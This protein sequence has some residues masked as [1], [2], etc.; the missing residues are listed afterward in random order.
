MEPA[1]LAA[2]PYPEPG[3]SSPR[4]TIPRLCRSTLIL[5]YHLLLGLPSGFCP[6]DFPAKSLHSPPMSFFLMWSPVLWLVDSK[7]SWRF[8]LCHFL[9]SPVTSLLLGPDIFLYALLSNTFSTYASFSVTDQFSFPYKTTGR[10][11][12]QYI[13]YS[14]LRRPRGCEILD[15]R[16]MMIFTG[17]IMKWD[18]HHWLRIE[19]GWFSHPKKS[20]G[21]IWR[22]MHRASSCNM[23]INQQD[24]QISVIKLYFPLDTLHVSVYISPSSGAT[25]Y[26]SYIAF[27]MFSNIILNVNVQ[28]LMRK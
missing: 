2:S 17:W 4:P 14:D 11:M 18:F 9:H 12:Y 27:G 1:V 3:K 21:R 19:D 10:I 8:S 23:Y 25:F 28:H 16:T 24:A 7:M 22:C 6:S 15:T 13:I 5:S 26:K 20:N